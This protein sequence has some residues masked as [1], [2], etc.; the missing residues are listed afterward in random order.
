MGGS[1]AV[2]VRWGCK[3]SL[4]LRLG[5]QLGFCKAG[6]PGGN[7]YAVISVQISTMPTIHRS[8]CIPQGREGRRTFLVFS[9]EIILFS[10]L[11]T[12]LKLY[13]LVLCQFSK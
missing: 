6:L 5:C 9:F 3:G 2:V 10:A 7:V 1:S 12:A 11:F 4:V 13:L 8:Q